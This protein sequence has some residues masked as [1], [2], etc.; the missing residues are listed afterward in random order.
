VP[1]EV[2][3]SETAFAFQ[4]DEASDHWRTDVLQVSDLLHLDSEAEELGKADAHR[5]KCSW[6][7]VVSCRP[8]HVLVNQRTELSSRAQYLFNLIRPLTIL[9]AEGLLPNL[10]L[11]AEHRAATLQAFSNQIS[12]IGIA[13]AAFLAAEGVNPL[14]W[15]KTSRHD[16]RAARTFTW[17]GVIIPLEPRLPSDEATGVLCYLGWCLHQRRH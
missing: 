16:V 14:R 17:S 7:V 12:A 13:I 15:I 11:T 2:A 9:I 3:T 10:I 1:N 4:S 6:P 8:G 5:G